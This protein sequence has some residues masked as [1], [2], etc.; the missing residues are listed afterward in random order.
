MP[1]TSKG[2]EIMGA[3]Q[4]Q[5]GEEKGKQVFYA[6]KNAGKISGVDTILTD[7]QPNLD[8][9]PVQYQEPSQV[10]GPAGPE[11]PP[12]NASACKVVASLDDLK[13]M[14]RGRG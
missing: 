9:Q 13:R 10:A 2:E 3:M 5:Y 1:L 6:S 11:R 12:L 14:G 7:P 4:N 8:Q